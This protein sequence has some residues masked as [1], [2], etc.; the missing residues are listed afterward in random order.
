MLWLLVLA[1]V[2][3]GIGAGFWAFK[4]G[5]DR[6]NKHG[7]QEYKTALGAFGG[8]AAQSALAVV[9]FL[10]LALGS[11]GIVTLLDVGSRGR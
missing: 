4:L 9:C 2:A 3:V 8:R 11:C 1:I 10:C 5:F 6:T 7:V